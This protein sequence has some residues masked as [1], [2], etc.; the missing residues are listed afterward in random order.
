MTIKNHEII[1]EK[2]NI[3]GSWIYKEIVGI[4][5][6]IDIDYE[7]NYTTM[8]NLFFFVSV[9]ETGQRFKLKVRYHNV[10][11]LTLRKVTNLYLT[12]SLIVHDN[13]ELGWDSNQRYHVHDDS[14]YGEN[15]GYNFIDFYCSSI[16][17]ISLEEF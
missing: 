1:T 14:G 2:L 9:I 6:N 12:R 5:Y 11:E 4:D 16:E 15:D 3:L 7:D 8:L 10:S 13:K 17:A